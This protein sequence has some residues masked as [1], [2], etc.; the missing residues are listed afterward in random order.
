MLNPFGILIRKG[1]KG[2]RK[3]ALKGLNMNKAKASKFF[4]LKGLNMNN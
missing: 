4:T 2:R 3:S 1:A